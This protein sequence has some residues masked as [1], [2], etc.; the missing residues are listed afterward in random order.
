MM[1]R[2]LSLRKERLTKDAPVQSRLGRTL[3]SPVPDDA[4]LFEFAFTKPWL[5]QLALPRH[6]RHG[7]G[8]ASGCRGARRF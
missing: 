7:H 3:V 6:R 2:S 8:A 1:Q 5:R 4:V